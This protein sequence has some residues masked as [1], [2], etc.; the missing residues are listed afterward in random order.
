MQQVLNVLTDEQLIVNRSSGIV[1]SVSTGASDLIGGGAVGTQ[2]S[3]FA[4]ISDRA[5]MEHQFR[6]SRGQPSDSFLA[7]LHYMDS[8]G[9]PTHEF[10]VRIIIYEIT[11]HLL[12]IALQ[13]VGEVRLCHLGNRSAEQPPMSNSS[14]A[15]A[16]TEGPSLQG[17][18]AAPAAHQGHWGDGQQ[19]TV[20]GEEEAAAADHQGLVLLPGQA[21]SESSAVHRGR[22]GD[23]ETSGH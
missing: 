7:T 21:S 15:L 16:L 20:H 9:I 23:G 8:N 10:E 17:D 18:R 13:L 2:V 5:N 4:H 1:V 3:Q 12:H 19:S 6:T 14:A 11:G 22:Q